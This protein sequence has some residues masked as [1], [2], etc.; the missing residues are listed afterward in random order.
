[1]AKEKSKIAEKLILFTRYPEPGAV[2]T[3]LIPLLGPEG[4]A[5]LQRR[6]A[7]AAAQEAEAVCAQRPVRFEIC[8]DGGKRELVEQWIASVAPNGCCYPQGDGDLGLRMERAF[9]RAFAE[10]S[11]RVLLRGSD[12]PDLSAEIM[13][14]AFEALRGH[15]LVIGPA[16]DGGYYL[17]GLAAPQPSLF[18][19][20][21]WGDEAVLARTLKRAEA[22][23]L[24]SFL[25]E[26]LADVDRPEDL[27][28][29][30]HY[31]HP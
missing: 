29:F 4:A 3:R 13:I 26:Y 21:E 1:M 23:G 11:R 27:R 31:S 18:A 16:F 28:H 10:G 7:E 9:A 25:L 15:D 12:C 2:K 6:M 30:D 19:D 8:F 5:D 22:A 17:L 14:R 20:M 24:R